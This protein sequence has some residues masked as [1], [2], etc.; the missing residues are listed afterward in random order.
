MSSPPVI[1]AETRSGILSIRKLQSY[2]KGSRSI[3][4]HVV[5]SRSGLLLTEL[6]LAILFF[7]LGSAV[8]I[9][10]FIQAH[11]DSRAAADLNFA[12]AQVSGA[13]S[14]L[15]HS[16]G[17]VQAV[18]EYYP[19]A[20]E[21]GEELR[22]CYDSSREQCPAEEAVYVMTIR[23]DTSGIRKDSVIT[24]TGE[25]GETLYQLDICYPS[26]AQEEKP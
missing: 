1:P 13:A 7:A 25:D 20:K 16:D 18:T 5:R 8:C 10:I 22:I 21:D 12:T 4:N 9:R 24:M 3:M 11:L 23:T 17:S 2:M 6:V 26:D 19:C 15:R 14:V